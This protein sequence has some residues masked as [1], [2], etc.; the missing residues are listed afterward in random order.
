MR[1]YPDVH[2]TF[3]VGVGPAGSVPITL[4]AWFNSV[5][6]ALYRAKESGRN[7]VVGDPDP[8]PP[9]TVSATPS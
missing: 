5:G 9:P 1:G 7:Q 2:P 6:C 4:R 3:S 8:A